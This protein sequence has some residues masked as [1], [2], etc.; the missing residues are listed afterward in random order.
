MVAI[1]RLNFLN[2]YPKVNKHTWAQ[3]LYG[4]YWCND[5][6]FIKFLSCHPT[7]HMGKITCRKNNL[8]VAL[9]K[10]I[11]IEVS[12]LHLYKMRVLKFYVEN[13]AL[14]YVC[15][16]PGRSHINHFNHFEALHSSYLSF[17]IQDIRSIINDNLY[18]CD[19]LGVAHR[20]LS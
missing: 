16:F 2:S 6:N 12:R 20:W 8:Q 1:L 14:W 5:R 15:C 17:I 10:V 18:Q 9:L 7:K 13:K 19:Y 11:L 3:N 4:T